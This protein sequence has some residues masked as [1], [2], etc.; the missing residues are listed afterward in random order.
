VEGVKTALVTGASRGIGE[1]FARQLAALGKDLVLVARDE[2]SLR[3]TAGEL[4]AAHGVRVHVIA[5][6]LS[7]PGAAAAIWAETARLGVEVDLLVNNAG[8]GK[9]GAFATLAGEAQAAMVRLNVNTPVELARLYLPGMRARR[10]GGIIN[11]ASNAA[12][13]PVPYLAIYAASKA[14]ILHFSEALAEEVGADGVRVMALCPGAT[15]TA[16]WNVA[17]I[18]ENRRG[19]MT[20][21]EKVVT[22]GLRAFARRR[23]FFVPGLGY[24]L[25]A[26]AA[27]RLGPRW[28]VRRIAGRLLRSA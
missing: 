7:L 5:A 21:P 25:V 26:F 8:L 9:R 27:S 10:R 13:Q 23:A 11:V 20:S 22:S 6:D 12:F 19:W 28:L 18:W 2:H 17:G 1:V 24:S 16:F 14:F 3:T 15:D 4:S